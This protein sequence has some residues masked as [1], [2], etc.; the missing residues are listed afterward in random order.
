MSLDPIFGLQEKEGLSM[1]E[2]HTLA[3]MANNHKLVVDNKEKG[4]LDTRTI[5]EDSKLAIVE[6]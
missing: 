4:I 5:E 3:S 6:G 1:L 2:T